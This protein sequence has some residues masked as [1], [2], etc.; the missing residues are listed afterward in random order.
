MYSALLRKSAKNQYIKRKIHG[1]IYLKHFR[2]TI[3]VF[4]SYINEISEIFSQ[5]K[6]C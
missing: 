5:E 1:C 2:K 3:I 6:M 4:L